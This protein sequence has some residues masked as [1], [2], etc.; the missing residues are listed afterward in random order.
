[1]SK[2]FVTAGTAVSAALVT[3]LVV[4]ACSSTE[5]MKGKQPEAPAM[6]PQAATSPPQPARIGTWGINLTDGDH[7]VKAGDDFYQYS[8]GHWL[9][10]NQI[11][12]DR[13]SWSTFAVLADEAEKQLRQLVEGL[14]PSAAAGSNEQKV[15][16]FYR[17]Y[18][19]TDNIEKLGLT[20]VRA[21]LD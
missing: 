13:T 20:P 16:D 1:M 11:P 8:V 17:A 21:S 5:P 7:S 12:A 10:S 14:P 15:G 2:H 3:A 4:T 9:N 6:E 19:D 18:L